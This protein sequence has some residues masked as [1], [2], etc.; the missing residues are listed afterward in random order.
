MTRVDEAARLFLERHSCSQAVFA[1]FAPSYGIPEPGALRLAAGLGGG[2]RAG[3][4]CGAALG[5]LLVLG[6]ALCDADCSA[7]SKHAVMGAVDAF[8]ARFQERIG[9]LDCPGILGYDVRD[10]EQN[11]MVKELGLRNTRCLEAVRVA[12][13]TLEELLAAE[14][15]A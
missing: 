12:A 2:L 1:A 7:D 5:A 10:P 8:H 9:A 14:G 11:A 6:P 3:S 13:E 15:D 4:M